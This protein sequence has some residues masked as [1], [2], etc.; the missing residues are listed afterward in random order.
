MC[1][2]YPVA[3]SA[4]ALGITNEKWKVSVFVK[5]IS[6]KPWLDTLRRS[7][8]IATEQFNRRATMTNK[9]IWRYGCSFDFRHLK[10][11]VPNSGLGSLSKLLPRDREER[12]TQ[13]LNVT[14]H[15]RAVLHAVR[16]QGP[17][18]T[19][20]QYSPPTPADEFGLA[21]FFVFCNTE[22]RRW[23]TA[24]DQLW[25]DVRVGWVWGERCCN[26]KGG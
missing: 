10:H 26:W 6:V 1:G 7:P 3:I 24:G 8:W 19:R 11:N 15:K 4:S 17:V 9:D 22:S 23:Q 21:R 16:S 2:W 25:L 12:N 13:S 14:P 18:S 20:C 5:L